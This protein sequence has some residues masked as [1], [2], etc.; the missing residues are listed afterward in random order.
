MCLFNRRHLNIITT[1]LLFAILTPLLW[2]VG[3]KIEG[4]LFPATSEIRLVD[5]Q[6]V[7]GGAVF[8]FSYSK[9]RNCKFVSM[10]WFRQSGLY[11]IPAK[12]HKVD[13]SDVTSNPEGEFLSSLWFVPIAVGDLDDAKAYWTHQCHPLWTITRRIH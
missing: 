7:D 12:P 4:Y 5:I 9:Y 3:P 10:D 8:R 6:S 13:G 11:A 1:I 2:T